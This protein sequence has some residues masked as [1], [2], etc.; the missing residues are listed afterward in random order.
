VTIKISAI[1]CR[2][3]FLANKRIWYHAI[4]AG[5]VVG[6]ISVEATSDRFWWLNDLFVNPS[7]RRGGIARQLLRH[8]INVWQ[9][10]NEV[11]LQGIV[12]ISCGID[13]ANVAS[14]NLFESCGFRHVYDYPESSTRLYSLTDA[15]QGG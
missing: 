4:I 11:E 9:F 15:P 2:S 8:I 3:E 7:S 14:I 1:D 5:Q 10:S 13:N 12:G 6:T